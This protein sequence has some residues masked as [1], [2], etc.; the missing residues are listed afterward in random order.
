[1]SKKKVYGA[2]KNEQA[3][4]FWEEYAKTQ[5]HTAAQL[6][7]EFHRITAETSDKQILINY[8]KMKTEEG[9]WHAVSDAANDLRVLEAGQ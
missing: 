7:A 8:L 4:A 3:R 6:N 2:F 1:M 9:D 5:R